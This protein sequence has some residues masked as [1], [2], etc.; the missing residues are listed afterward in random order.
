LVSRNPIIQRLPDAWRSGSKPCTLPPL[1]SKFNN[2]S[3]I[4]NSRTS[5]LFDIA[6]H[7][8]HDHERIDPFLYPPWRQTSQ[9]LE[10]RVNI[11]PSDKKP[12][13][14]VDEEEIDAATRHTELVEELTKS[15]SNL[16]IYSDG[17]L[18]KKSGFLRAGASVVVYHKGSGV[19][20][21]WEEERRSTTQKWQD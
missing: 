15:E 12:K 20:R 8:S 2:G 6:T 1:N 21:A 19:A 17:S 3:T 5:P 14:S 7:T 13:G 10:D 18:M 4:D 16:I 11:Q 9:S